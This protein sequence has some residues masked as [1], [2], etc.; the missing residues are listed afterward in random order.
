MPANFGVYS[1]TP[2]LLRVERVII[3]FCYFNCNSSIY[4]FIF[5]PLR[6]KASFS[7]AYAQLRSC[8]KA[9]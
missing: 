3:L 2:E 7:A 5:F 1:N 9:S 6:K 4:I 8:R